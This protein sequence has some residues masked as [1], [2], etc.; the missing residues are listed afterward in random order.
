MKTFLKAI[1]LVPIA[2]IVLAFAYANRQTTIVSFDP[3]NSEIPAF[4]MAGPLFIVLFATILVG[5]LI[6]GTAS[7]WSQGKR[8]KSLREARAE[9]DRL[10]DE[11]LRLKAAARQQAGTEVQTFPQTTAA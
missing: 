5:I 11:V 10:K 9:C 7:W 2:V 6:G 1:I 3:F 4:S 8:R